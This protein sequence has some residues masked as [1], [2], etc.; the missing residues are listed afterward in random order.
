MITDLNKGASGFF[1]IKYLEFGGFFL[2]G[3]VYFKFKS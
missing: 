1:N 2:A 3:E